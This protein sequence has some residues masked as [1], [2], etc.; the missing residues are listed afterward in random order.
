MTLEQIEEGFKSLAQAL[1]TAQNSSKQAKADIASITS[2]IKKKETEIE[3]ANEQEKAKKISLIS[4]SDKEKNKIQELIDVKNGEP[5]TQARDDVI[6]RLNGRILELDRTTDADVKKNFEE[7]RAKISSIQISIGELQKKL[8]AAEIAQITAVRQIQSAEQLKN[9]YRKAKKIAIAEKA[10]ND[11]AAKAAAKAEAKAE[12]KAAKEKAAAEAAAEAAAKAATEAAAKAEAK[13]AKEKAAA[14]AAAKAAAKAATEA[15][16]KAAKDAEDKKIEKISNEGQRKRLQASQQA[17]MALQKAE[18][19]A[20]KEKANIAAAQEER[21]RDER[22]KAQLDAIKAGKTIENITAEG[23]AKATEIENVQRQARGA[24][25]FDA[26]EG[27]RKRQDLLLEKNALAAHAKTKAEQAEAEATIAF[28]TAKQRLF[29]EEEALKK[30]YR[31]LGDIKT[32]E[33]TGMVSNEDVAYAE[34]FRRAKQSKVEAAMASKDAAYAT[35][36]AAAATRRALG[37]GVMEKAAA[38]LTAAA[39]KMLNEAT[40]TEKKAAQAEIRAQGVREAI[41]KENIDKAN[42]MDKELKEKRAAAEK[43][44]AEKTAVEKAAV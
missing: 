38:K 37:D 19:A 36:E 43:A 12:A 25:H 8:N 6:N 28:D 17:Y 41:R 22:S 2:K 16:A 33:I 35:L 34:A 13:A 11:A 30:S 20:Q 27:E 31:A 29:E 4:T 9:D 40:I 42:K 7:T 23:I 14:E 44:S 15:A 10:N 5:Q 21:L 26:L 1:N 39:N 3:T 18:T 32:K 24:S